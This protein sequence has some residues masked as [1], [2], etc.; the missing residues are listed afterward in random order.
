MNVSEV[1]KRLL[2]ADLK[3]PPTPSAPGGV[4]APAVRT[5]QLLF[6]SGHVPRREDGSVICGVVA[7][8]LSVEQS[9][10]AA[11]STALQILRT[12]DAAAGLDNVARAIKVLGFVRANLDFTQHPKVIDGFTNVLRLAFGE[13]GVPARSAIGAGGL[14]LGACLEVE[15]IFELKH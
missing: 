5:G 2:S 7:V 8:D 15:A 12:V 3:L 13:A 11:R 10:Q 6:V 14:P 1:E 4:Y 9:A